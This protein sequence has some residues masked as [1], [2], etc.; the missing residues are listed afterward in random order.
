MTA[1]PALRGMIRD[2]KWLQMRGEI[3]RHAPLSHLLSDSLASL[4]NEGLVDHD[5][6]RAACEDANDF[7]SRLE[8]PGSTRS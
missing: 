5:V 3:D 1:N 6:A 7:K 2:G 8:K 4:V